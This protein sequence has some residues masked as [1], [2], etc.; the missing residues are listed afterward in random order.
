MANKAVVLENC[1]GVVERKRRL[2]RQHQLGSSSRPRIATSSARP[3]F[4]P[5]Q[6]Q[7]QLMSHKAGQGFSTP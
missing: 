5:A 3:V 2:G 4:C 7:F 1:R 6:S